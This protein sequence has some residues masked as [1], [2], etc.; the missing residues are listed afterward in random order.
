MR[1]L[2]AD[3]SAILAHIVLDP[4]DW[5]TRAQAHPDPEGALAQK[6]ARWRPVYD[7]DKAAKGALYKTRA[8]R[9]TE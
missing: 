1:D 5:W 9:E 7:A 8:E 4:L 3:E 2:T 6:V